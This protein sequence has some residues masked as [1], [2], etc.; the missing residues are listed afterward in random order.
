MLAVVQWFLSPLGK[1]VI[2]VAAFFAWT[3]YQ[4]HDAASAERDRLT[5][6][7]EKTTADEVSRQTAAASAAVAA[8]EER[9]KATELQL[10]ALQETAD[11]LR[12]EVES[13]GLACP[14]DDTLRRKL[15]TI[16]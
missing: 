15:L 7:F 16:K 12:I 1:V 11:A 6:A 5:A 8:A 4:R 3:E 14:V 2:L 9:A 13:S 10:V